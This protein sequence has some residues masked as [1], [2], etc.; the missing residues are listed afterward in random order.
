MRSSTLLA[1]LFATLGPTACG[2]C[3]DKP[4]TGGTDSG[5]AALTTDAAP[6]ASAAS[7]AS[8]GLG[9]RGMAMRG[10]PG[11]VGMLVHS[12]K[13]LT[14]K[15]EQ[16]AKLDAAEKSMKGDDASSRDEMKSFHT[17]L[18]AGVK[19][20]KIDQAKIDADLAAL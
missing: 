8:A 5:S 4:T 14:L 13:S 20:G 11:P 18:A 17:N 12:A 3:D 10:A 15:D 7:S 6:S 19:A 16:K 1:I 2:S 9:R